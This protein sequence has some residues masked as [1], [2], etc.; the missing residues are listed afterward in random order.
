VG[1]TSY[2]DSTKHAKSLKEQILYLAS[3][4]N[5]LGYTCEPLF[6]DLF[7]YQDYCIDISHMKL[8]VFDVLLQ[9]MISHV[10][11]TGK[12]GAE[13]MSVIERKISILSQHCER[14]V[15]KHF[16]LQ[17]KSDDHDEILS[18]DITK[19]AR[20]VVNKFEEVLRELKHSH[21]VRKGV[22]KRLVN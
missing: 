11:R 22:L 5:E 14:T 20:C 15:G 16:F 18:A 9:D 7:D 6:E 21:N 8:R 4:T 17:V 2:H 12:Y 13:H 10:S 3:G 1:A 19:S